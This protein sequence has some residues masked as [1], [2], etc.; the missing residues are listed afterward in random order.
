MRRNLR[1]IKLSTSGGARHSPCQPF[2]KG[3]LP[4][5]GP[6]NSLSNFP[7]FYSYPPFQEQLQAGVSLW[8]PRPQSS[9][10]QRP[11]ELSGGCNDGT[12]SFSRNV[13]SPIT[14]LW[15]QQN[16][17]RVSRVLPLLPQRCNL[18]TGAPGAQK[19]SLDSLRISLEIQI[20]ASLLFRV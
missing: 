8:K 1:E 17:G 9:S 16:Q 19:Q 6:V 4:K 18:K 5:A 7:R 12:I 14:I 11:T 3:Q 15:Q 20:A 10:P 13:F 2:S